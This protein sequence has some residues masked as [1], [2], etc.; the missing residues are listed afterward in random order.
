MLKN[1]IH[2]GEFLKEEL[3]TRGISQSKLAEHIGVEPG[4]INLLCNGRRGV[5]ASMAKKLAKALETSAEL[6]M[7]LQVSYELSQADEPKFGKLRA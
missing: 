5:S 4:V 2:P 1:N 3:E 7:N 6:W